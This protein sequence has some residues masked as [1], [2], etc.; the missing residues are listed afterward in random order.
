MESGIRL[1]D[2]SGLI[3]DVKFIMVSLEVI[4][5]TRLSEAKLSPDILHLDKRQKRPNIESI[6]PYQ[7]NS[8]SLYLY[9][10]MLWKGLISFELLSVGR[11]SKLG[12]GVLL[13]G[14][15]GN[16][17]QQPRFVFAGTSGPRFLFVFLSFQWIFSSS[18][19]ENPQC[20]VQPIDPC[21]LVHQ[22]AKRPS[23]VC[24]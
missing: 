6:F 24:G 22:L 17:A 13:R 4:C 8:K 14:K 11:R 15:P 12:E 1:L 3:T 19:D 20:Q 23:T 2:T 7:L 18:T 9:W 10:Q 5:R 16:A 21:S